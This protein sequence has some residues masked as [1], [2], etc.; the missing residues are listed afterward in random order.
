[1][2]PHIVLWCQKLNL[3]FDGFW[4]LLWLHRHRQAIV[5]SHSRARRTVWTR[6]AKLLTWAR[7]EFEVKII[8]VWLKSFLRLIDPKIK[9]FSAPA[10]QKKLNS[11]TKS[12]RNVVKSSLKFSGY[13]FLKTAKCWQNSANTQ[14]DIISFQNIFKKIGVMTLFASIAEGHSQFTWII[15]RDGRS[16][17]NVHLTNKPKTYVLELFTRV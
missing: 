6:T 7:V 11:R 13:C 4:G 1:M 16:S 9:N 2:R 3:G 5:F 10:F 17:S 15:V 12:R 14:I 8:I